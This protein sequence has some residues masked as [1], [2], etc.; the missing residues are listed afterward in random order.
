[1]KRATRLAIA[2]AMFSACLATLQPQQAHAT[3]MVATDCKVA[4]NPCPVGDVLDSG[5]R[6]NG[7]ATLGA[8]RYAL[9]P[10]TFVDASTSVTGT[11]VVANFAAKFIYL[12]G[13]GTATSDVGPGISISRSRRT[14]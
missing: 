6:S 11:V 4:F 13:F 5:I 3:T 10:F 1:M 2:L 9:L 14:I 8:N 7:V 12:I